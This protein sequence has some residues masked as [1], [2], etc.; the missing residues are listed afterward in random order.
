MAYSLDAIVKPQTK[1]SDLYWHIHID[2]EK[3]RRDGWG[4]FV[5]VYKIS[6]YGSCWLWTYD[7][8]ASAFL[9]YVRINSYYGI[10]FLIGHETHIL[11]IHNRPKWWMGQSTTLWLDMFIG[12]TYRGVGEG[13]FTVV[14]MIEKQLQFWKSYLNRVDVSLSCNAGAPSIACRYLNKWKSL[15]Q[16]VCLVRV[17]SFSVC[18]LGEGPSWILWV[19]CFQGFMLVYFLSPRSPT[20]FLEGMP[21]F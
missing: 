17:S 21:K 12:V 19:L 13:L 15:L 4:T 8:S 7:P 10:P 5:C 18:D 9:L 1:H 20:F 6:L 11:G 14:R 3:E 2:K 16:V